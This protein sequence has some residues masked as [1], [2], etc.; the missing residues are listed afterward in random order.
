MPAPITAQVIGRRSEVATAP[1]SRTVRLR[2]ATTM[3]VDS[4]PMPRL[5][6][7][8][9]TSVGIGPSSSV[10]PKNSPVLAKVRTS[11]ATSSAPLSRHR[12]AISRR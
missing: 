10:I 1:D 4:T 3:D 8:T 12:R 9:V 11:S 7:S 6:P 2:R 5:L